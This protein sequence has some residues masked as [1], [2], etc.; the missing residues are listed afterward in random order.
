MMQ[1]AFWDSHPINICFL[2][3]SDS[4]SMYKALKTLMNVI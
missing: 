3:V 4:A 1:L 2:V